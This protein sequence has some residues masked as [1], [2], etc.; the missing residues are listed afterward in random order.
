MNY[1]AQNYNR[2]R[3]IKAKNDWANTFYNKR[4]GEIY[5]SFNGDV[6]QTNRFEDFM[7]SKFED[8]KIREL[9]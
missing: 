3:I 4:R 9:L 1:R 5:N 7:D 2:E 8:K 6:L